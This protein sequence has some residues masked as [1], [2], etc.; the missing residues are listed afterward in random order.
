MKLPADFI[1]RMR[2]LLGG[3]FDRFAEAL[4]ASQPVSIRI[5]P[6]KCS[7]EPVDAERVGWSSNGYYLKQ[8]PSFTFDPLFHSGCYY[9]Q[10]ASSMFVEQ[11]LKRFVDKPVRLLDLCAAPGG[12]TTLSLATLPQGS[13]VVANEYV[14]Q[15]ARVLAENVTKWGYSNAIV[16][17]NTPADYGKLHHTF[18]VIVVDAPCSGEGM[19]RK[20][21]EA[22]A[23][24][25]I[26]NVNL[27]V[28]RQKSILSDVWSALKP[29]GVIIYS[30]CTFNLEENEEMA[31]FMVDEFGAEPMEEVELDESWGV[32]RALKGSV[33]FYRFMPHK[34]VGEGFTVT[35][36]Q[37]PE[38]DYRPLKMGKTKLKTIPLPNNLKPLLKDSTKFEY[39]LLKDTV[40]AL[41]PECKD[42]L[43]LMDKFNIFHCGISVAVTDKG[44]DYIPHHALSQ[45]VELNMA[46]VSKIEVDYKEAISYLRRE[47][48]ALAEQQR[49]IALVTY[50]GYPLGWAKCVGNRANNLYPQEWRIRNQMSDNYVQISLIG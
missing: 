12:K 8:R 20:D 22:V 18:D 21:E 38:G 39:T 32:T 40:V 43:L 11:L 44:K 50:S 36:M 15:R 10:E 49:G 9:V 6:L 31:Q 27:C 26:D 29:G 19:F 25:S 41:S 45:S 3:D 1:T 13:I 5:N 33:P 4:C 42:M 35:A 28:E 47:A 37:K 23:Q 17:N 16:T 34:A 30:T 46:E 14:T 24:W 7:G 2:P 48:M